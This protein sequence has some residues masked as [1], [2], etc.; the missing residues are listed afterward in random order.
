MSSP[1]TGSRAR[2]AYVAS[3]DR[4][5]LEPCEAEGADEPS[6]PESSASDEERFLLR[7]EPQRRHGPLPFAV[8]VGIFLLGWLLIL[9]GIAG[10]VLPGI[11]GVFTIVI[12]ATLLSLDNELAYRLL[13]RCFERWPKIW[14][15]VEAY[16]DKLHVK[17]QRFRKH[18]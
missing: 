4:P 18:H 12:G 1:S 13:R 9:I 3:S 6:L 2:R 16:R 10:L 5:D 17:L 11:Q 15:R 7:L 14:L 8:R